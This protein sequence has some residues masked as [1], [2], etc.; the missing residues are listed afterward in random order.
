MAYDVCEWLWIRSILKDLG[1]EYVTPTSLHCDNK[2]SIE[3]T[4]NPAQY[5]FTKYVE[6]DPYFKKDLKQKVIQFPFVK[7]ES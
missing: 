2:T 6:V 4:Y 5:Y 3:I 7:F 1:N